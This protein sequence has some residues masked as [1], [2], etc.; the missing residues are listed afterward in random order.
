MSLKQWQLKSPVDLSDCHP[1]PF[2]CVTCTKALANGMDEHSYLNRACAM[3]KL[4]QKSCVSGL[5]SGFGQQGG[6]DREDRAVTHHA[7]AG[8]FL[9]H[10]P[11][12]ASPT[13][14]SPSFS[15]LIHWTLKKCFCAPSKCQLSAASGMQRDSGIMPCDLSRSNQCH[16]SK[17]ATTSGSGSALAVSLSQP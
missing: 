2:R 7:Q 10:W 11:P 3:P 12:W 14:A 9:W 15:G 17:F 5:P 4:G 8:G 13:F 6:K 16:P 1:C